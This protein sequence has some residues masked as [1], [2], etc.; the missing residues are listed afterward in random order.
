M[1][2]QCDTGIG[3]G[4]RAVDDWTARVVFRDDSATHRTRAQRGMD[5]A[6]GV[7]PEEHYLNGRWIGCG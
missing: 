2:V 4:E 5:G 6:R 1:N 3:G 7:K